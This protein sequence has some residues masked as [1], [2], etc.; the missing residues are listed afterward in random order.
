MAAN[1][2]RDDTELNPWG[3]P[4]L[5]YTDD[6]IV[7][8]KFVETIHR[9]EPRDRSRGT[10]RDPDAIDDLRLNES[11]DANN[12]E[13]V[14]IIRRMER[15]R[16]EEDTTEHGGDLA[17]QSTSLVITEPSESVATKQSTTN[18]ADRGSTYEALLFE[19]REIGRDA[20]PEERVD[21]IESRLK[22]MRGV[23]PHLHRYVKP[24]PIQLPFGSR[25][26]KISGGND[27]ALVLLESDS[28]VLEESDPTYTEH[29]GRVLVMGSDE[30]SQLGLQTSTS[31][32]IP[33]ALDTIGDVKASDVAAGGYHSILVTKANECVTWG[34][35]TSGCTGQGEAGV[36]REHDVPRWMYWITNATTKVVSCAAGDAHT[37]ITSV[38]GHV[39]SFGSG[40]H[41]QL[42]HT[43]GLDYA[44]PKLVEAISKL[45]VVTIVCGGNHT[46]VLTTEG[47]VYG[48][49]SN[50]HGQLG[51][52]VHSDVFHPRRL[53]HEAFVGG[54]PTPVAAE[55]LYINSHELDSRAVR[56]FSELTTKSDPNVPKSTNTPKSKVIG[57]AAG[58][59]HTVLLTEKG[60]VFVCGGGSHGQLGLR[61]RD[62]VSSVTLLSTMITVSVTQ[63]GAGDLH[64]VMLTTLGDV[65]VCG[66]NDF[67]QLGDGSVKG[68]HRPQKMQPTLSTTDRIAMKTSA[69][70]EILRHPLYG[71][72]AEK[73]YAS[74]SSTFVVARN[75]NTLYVCGSGAFGH[76]NNEH[77]TN[78][79]ELINEPVTKWNRD[80]INVMTSTFAN[81]RMDEH[82]FGT[83]AK[84]M[85]MYGPYS[86][87]VLAHV[88]KSGFEEALLKP[89]MC[90]VYVNMIK[91]IEK[92]SKGCSLLSFRRVLMFAVEDLGVRLLKCRNESQR[93]RLLSNLGPV[94]F[95]RLQKRDGKIDLQQKIDSFITDREGFQDYQRFKSHCVTLKRLVRELHEAGVLL[96]ADL[97]D[98]SAG[99]P[100]S[101]HSIGL[102][103]S[104]DA[105]H[106]LAFF[107]GIANVKRE[108]KVT[109]L[110]DPHTGRT[111][112]SERMPDLV[113]SAK[114]EAAWSNPTESNT[115]REYNKNHAE[116]KKLRAMSHGIPAPR[117]TNICESMLKASTSNIQ[118]VN[119]STTFKSG[120]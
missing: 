78:L 41:G 64:T 17:L 100:G 101:N 46:L 107:Q 59:M 37:F 89:Q 22:S 88:F 72:Q 55:E 86:E 14:R 7:R 19:E 67:G 82:I 115:W 95:Q 47:L 27:H 81:L 74:K 79:S 75:T 71:I 31:Q 25:V 56:E 98:M 120:K 83:L 113:S 70:E 90:S 3:I 110:V 4:V 93:R 96:S 33:V 92:H 34:K 38:S 53:V 60:R 87:S 80:Q 84:Q 68:R 57:A 43:D 24:F 40:A 11:D 44:K 9:I 35:D 50:S 77:E 112:I 32:L 8:Q 1:D 73:V 10:F 66:A 97:E 54:V 103:D 91:M 39:Y 118:V 117:I 102:V 62:D 119:I 69:I 42:G 106:K 63:V 108:K 116:E 21:Y 104:T 36:N 29:E 114:E 105:G 12:V 65:F 45:S 48:F 6:D 18:V 94:S 49:G 13:A 85:I 52:A 26:K 99:F 58:K 30:F 51:N 2:E 5:R 15:E 23:P 28:A 109:T 76:P 111:E 61:A 20:T 16:E